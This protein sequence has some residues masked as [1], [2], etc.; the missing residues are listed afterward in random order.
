MGVGKDHEQN[1][2]VH[3]GRRKAKVVETGTAEAEAIDREVRENLIALNREKAQ[4][5]EG[6]KPL[7]ASLLK[8]FP[9]KRY[10]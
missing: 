8:Q 10:N 5:V 9:P 7:F 2:R 4:P 3:Y 6:Y 1:K